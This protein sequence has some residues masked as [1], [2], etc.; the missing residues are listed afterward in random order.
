MY[1]GF[2]ADFP[3]I[4]IHLKN[5]H[6]RRP[7][8]HQRDPERAG[9]IAGVKNRVISWGLNGSRGFDVKTFQLARITRGQQFI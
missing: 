7:G 3:T 4:S 9:G 6:L 1:K 8:T 2:P 5:E